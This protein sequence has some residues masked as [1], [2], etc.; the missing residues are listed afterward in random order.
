MEPAPGGFRI[1]VL[2]AHREWVARTARALVRGDAEAGDLEQ[3]AWLGILERPP[4][5]APRS[6]RAW[7]RSVLRF[8]SADRARASG[9][10][11]RH[12]AAAARPE[13]GIPGA[14]EVVSRA[15]VA[16]RVARAVL[17]LEEPFR[18]TV[19]LRY[20]EGLEPGEIARRMGI[21]PETAR[22]RLHRAGNGSSVQQLRSLAEQ[23]DAHTSTIP[24]RNTASST[25]RHP[26]SKC[27]I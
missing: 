20:F 3:D 18:T 5:A 2:L 7:L 22:T 10:R 17:A 26:G 8:R 1:E 15:E 21:P 24:K 14:E 9:A 4:A 16:E 12:E 11:R 13:G 19:L 25:A 27:F 6:P 23:S